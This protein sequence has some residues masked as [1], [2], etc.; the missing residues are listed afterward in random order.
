MLTFE[1]NQLRPKGLLLSIRNIY[2]LPTLLPYN[3][4]DTESPACE[5]LGLRPNETA[6][7]GKWSKGVGWLGARTS[8]NLETLWTRGALLAPK[9]VL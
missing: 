9:P 5:A 4:T 1:H 2:T 8:A 7:Q 6:A 3:E